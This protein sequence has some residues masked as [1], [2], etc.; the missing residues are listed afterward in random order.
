MSK[1]INMNQKVFFLG[2]LI[3]IIIFAIFIGCSDDQNASPLDLNEATQKVLSDILHNDLDSLAFYRY[4]DRL[5]SGAE[6]GYYQDPQ[7]TEPYKASEP[8]WF[9]FIDD[10]PGM[11]WAHPCRYIFVPASGSKISVIN[12]Q[13]PPDIYDALNLYYDL[14]TAIQTVISDI[15]FDSLA[16]K[17]LY[18]APNILAPGTKIVRPSGGQ[19]ILE[20][21]SWFIFIDDLPGAFYAHPC[22]YVLLELWGGKISIYDEQWPPDLALELYVSP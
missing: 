17:D 14:D 2:G 7:P 11:R 4:P 8:S 6:V 20:K 19:I 12:E 15:L 21:Y 9:F 16:L 22:R 13:W 3:L 1:G 18:Y 5:P 10:A